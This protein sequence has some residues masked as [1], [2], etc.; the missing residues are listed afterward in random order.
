[1]LRMRLFRMSIG[2]PSTL[3]TCRPMISLP[4]VPETDAPHIQ[5]K[6]ASSRS[7][8]AHFQ[9]NTKGNS[10]VRISCRRLKVDPHERSTSSCKRQRAFHRGSDNDELESVLGL[11]MARLLSF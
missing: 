6:A 9:Q 7:S 5:Q 11:F 1:M 8:L 10:D 2:F 3:C 4:K